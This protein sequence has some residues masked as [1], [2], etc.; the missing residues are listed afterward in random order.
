MDR[1]LWINKLKATGIHLGISAVI[2]FIFVYILLYHWYPLPYF[3]SDGGW[4]GMRIMLFVDVVLGPV[5]TLIVFNHTKARNKILFDLS[6]IGLIQLG[7]LIWGFNAVYQGRPVVIVFHEGRFFSQEA[8]SFTDLGVDT[9]SIKGEGKPPVVAV[10]QLKGRA[11]GEARIK[12]YELGFGERQILS[13]YEPVSKNLEE[14]SAYSDILARTLSQ[15]KDLSK[16]LTHYLKKNNLKSEDMNIARYIGKF[17]GGLII[18]DEKGKY[19]H[20]IIE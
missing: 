8:R 20:T 13:S 11:D 18:F 1:S 6:I 4:Q 7:A 9:S 19:I 10:S 3:H 17:S 16:K 14:F 2:F 12:M 5:L 15:N